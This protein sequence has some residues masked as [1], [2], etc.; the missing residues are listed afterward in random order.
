MKGVSIFTVHDSA[1][2]FLGDLETSLK[3]RKRVEA[4][5]QTRVGEYIEVD[6]ACH[7]CCRGGGRLGTGMG[8]PRF[9]SRTARKGIHQTPRGFS[10]TLRCRSSRSERQA[11]R[12]RAGTVP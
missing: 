2:E 12:I 7:R 6:E 9:S 1:G 5:L 4:A 3:P 8:A 11:S 10:C